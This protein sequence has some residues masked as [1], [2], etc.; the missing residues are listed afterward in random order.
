MLLTLDQ[1]FEQGIYIEIYSIKIELEN[2]SESSLELYG[3]LGWDFDLPK[4]KPTLAS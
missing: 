1:S 2:G 4:L 3:N